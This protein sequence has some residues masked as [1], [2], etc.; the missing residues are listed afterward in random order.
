M[1]RIRTIKP[2]F[3]GDDKVARLSRDER[4][5]CLGLISMADDDGRFMAAPTAVQGFVFPHDDLPPT[6]VRR[7]LD[8]LDSV[9][10]IHLYDVNGLRYG[11]LPGFARHQ[12][13]N[14]SSKSSL[15]E[16]PPETLL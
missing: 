9:G 8:R 5:L 7:W 1:A 6:K 11:Q 2:S 10:F 13:I 3:W 4:L 14:R 12:V 16:P 15:P